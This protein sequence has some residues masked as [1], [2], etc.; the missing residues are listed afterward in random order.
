MVDEFVGRAEKLVKKILQSLLDPIEIRT[1]VKLQDLIPYDEYILFDT[2][3][4]KHKFD[5]VVEQ[6]NKKLIVVEV[7]YK[8]GTKAAF[9]WNNVFD[10]LLRKH[11]HLIL[12]VKDYECDY[13]FK[14]QDYSKH[15]VSWYDVID[16]IHALNMAN[17]HVKELIKDV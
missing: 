15:K 11:G 5:M 1:Q 8:H 4:Q 6:K 17:I 2:E 7:N 9:K 16:V 12:L 10:A 3:F 14:P 13:L